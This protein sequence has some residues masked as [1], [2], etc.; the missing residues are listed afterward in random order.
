M[1]CRKDK[2]LT[3]LLQT[4]S[5]S[6]LIIFI[7]NLLIIFMYF[8]NWNALVKLSQCVYSTRTQL[9]RW[10]K[11]TR[12]SPSPTNWSLLSSA[13]CDE[14][15]GRHW[16]STAQSDEQTENSWCERTTGKLRS[17]C[18]RL[19]PRWQSIVISWKTTAPGRPTAASIAA[20]AS[21]A[22][23]G[24]GRWCRRRKAAN[25]STQRL[26]S[27]SRRLPTSKLSAFCCCGDWRISRY[28]ISLVL[29]SK[30]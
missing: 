30:V 10:I 27:I 3:K 11:M 5:E 13:I 12:I 15:D 24:G 7:T 9:R 14:G 26:K 2:L 22:E 23:C 21:E 4:Y 1:H 16:S 19:A 8:L 25:K 17:D 28:F 6:S 18:T 29:P 20:A